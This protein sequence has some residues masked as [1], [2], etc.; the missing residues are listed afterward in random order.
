MIVPYLFNRVVLILPKPVI[1]NCM[2]HV[3]QSHC[4][5]TLIYILQMGWKQESPETDGEDPFV[6]S[7]KPP[8]SPKHVTPKQNQVKLMLGMSVFV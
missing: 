2:F 1:M 8:T 4:T 3:L 7:H 5:S 6:D